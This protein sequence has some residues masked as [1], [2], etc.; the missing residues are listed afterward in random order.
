MFKKSQFIVYSLLL[1]GGLAS[2]FVVSFSLSP[3]TQKGNAQSASVP[4]VQARAIDEAALKKEIA[5]L[6]AHDLQVEQNKQAEQRRLQAKLKKAQEDTLRIQEKN[7]ALQRKQAQR[8]QERQAQIKREQAKVDQLKKEHAQAAQKH[9]KRLEQEK[10]RLAKLKSEQDR[11][12]EQVKQALAQKQA[13]ER[14]AQTIS[15][16][17]EEAQKIRA[18]KLAQAQ[19]KAAKE[20]RLIKERMVERQ[21]LQHTEVIRERV[22]GN[23]L[24]PFDYSNQDYS[25]EFLI[26]LSH[27]GDI[28]DYSISKSSGNEDFDKSALQA[29][30]RASPFPMPKDPEVRKALSEFTFEFKPKT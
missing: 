4:I 27:S 5:R 10:D 2:L 30:L 21:A 24:M 28:L 26:K 14:Q 3:T 7:K 1:H 23:W 16:A 22:S 18:Q 11:V 8:D 17:L 25:C 20:A 6:N 13:A 19:E 12:Q 29:L 15:Q 9:Q